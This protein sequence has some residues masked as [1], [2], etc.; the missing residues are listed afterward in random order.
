[1]KKRRKPR[2]SQKL[3]ELFEDFIDDC[4]LKNLSEKSIEN[5][6]YNCEIFIE[7]V[8]DIEV[9]NLNQ[10]TLDD[11]MKWLDE[12]RHYNPTSK[13]SMFIMINVFLHWLYEKGFIHEKLKFK[14]IKVDNKIK[15]IYTNEELKIIL[16]KPH[17]DCLFS[18]YRNYLLAHLIMNLG[19]RVR[20]V[21]EI[22]ISDVDMKNKTI[23]LHKMKNR[24]EIIMS[25]PKPLYK[26]LKEYFQDYEM[27][28]EDYLICDDKGKHM[29]PASITTSFKRYCKNRNIY[30]DGSVH[31]L[32]HTYAT[33]FVKNG[34]SIYALSKILGHSSVSITETYLRSLGVEQFKE[35][36]EEFN[37]ISH[38]KG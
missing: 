25:I 13:N 32:R 26:V 30:K 16:R 33:K 11:F 10:Q 21:S 38:L 31:L 14:R 1:M 8:N 18:E 19:L 12:N 20:T 3:S 23:A 22:K 17:E 15:E 37:P 36:L 4:R 35:E 29:K 7:A 27:N 24:Q 2:Y 34:G 9:K 6:N 5:Y 28:D